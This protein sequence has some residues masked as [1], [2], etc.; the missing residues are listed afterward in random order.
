MRVLAFGFVA[1]ILTPATLQFALDSPPVTEAV[2]PPVQWMQLTLGR[3]GGEKIV[4]GRDE[5]LFY[6]PDVDFITGRWPDRDPL[7]AVVKFHED[8]KALDIDL[9]VV[10]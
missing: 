4:V 3:Y 8:L 2:Q 9:V 7:P 1:I 6:R 10:P 5:W